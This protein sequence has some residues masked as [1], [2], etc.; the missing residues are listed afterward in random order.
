MFEV[1]CKENGYHT[2]VYAVDS[3][4]MDHPCF[5]LYNRIRGIWWWADSS[6]YEPVADTK[7][8]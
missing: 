2:T 4:S 7:N 8:R 5:L 6:Y 3:S 1:I